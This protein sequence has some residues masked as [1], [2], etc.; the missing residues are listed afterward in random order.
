VH[1]AA[2]VIVFTV[3]SGA[4][5]GLLGL[6]G[7]LG[8]LGWLPAGRL[9]AVVSLALAVAL[10]TIGLLSSASHLGH[11]ERAW[12]ALSQW[13][14]SWL[15]REGVAAALTYP[16]AG[17]FALA[18]LFSDGGPDL[19]IAGAATT[20]MCVVTVACTA[21]IYASLKPIR[22]WYSG[23]VLPNYL[24]LALASGGVWLY[25]LALVYGGSAATHAPAASLVLV[26]AWALKIAYWR[27]IDGGTGRS[28]AGSATG[29]GGIGAVRLLDPPHTE[30]NFL[31]QEMGFKI[32]RKHAGRLRRIA[33]AG[34]FAAPLGLVLLGTLTPAWAGAVFGV[35]AVVL[36][37]VGLLIER[38]L[39]FAEATHTVT[40]YYGA[41]AA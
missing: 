18:W 17:L 35:L 39:F 13:R 1:P 25:A 32:A 8:T 26:V 19:A 27:A 30:E 36:M 22:Q 21:M 24:A 20:V 10:I 2:S 15:S 7:A 29:L 4:G 34:A 5:Y 16:V 14:S 33:Q 28:D 12:R 38:W 31:Q 6:L 3:F 37:T 11:P 40:L 23:W 41:H 9:F